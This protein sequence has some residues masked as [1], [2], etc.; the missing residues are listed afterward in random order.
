MPNS[1]TILMA[2][3]VALVRSFA[4]PVE[5]CP[6]TSSSAA[7]PPSRTA[8]VSSRYP[9]KRRCLSSSGKLLGGPQCVPGRQNGDLDHR[10]GVLAECRDQRV[11]ALVR[12]DGPFLVL[13]QHVAA[14]PLP[15]QDAV[16]RRDQVLLSDVQP[17]IA[18]RSDCCF[19]Q[20]AREVG[21]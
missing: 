21:A 9:A 5:P 7:R 18:H 6:Y 19:V 3:L 11:P 12:G 8:S 10:V 20:Q 16:P 17:V 1:P 13:A 15:H 2:R 4:A 14:V